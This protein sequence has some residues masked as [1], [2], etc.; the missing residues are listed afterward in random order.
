MGLKGLGKPIWG[1]CFRGAS[2]RPG[3]CLPPSLAWLLQEGTSVIS[4]SQPWLRTPQDA[5]RVSLAGT[6]MFPSLVYLM[7]EEEGSFQGDEECQKVGLMV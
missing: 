7:E 4:P 3:C 5:Y 2:A 6:S 1:M